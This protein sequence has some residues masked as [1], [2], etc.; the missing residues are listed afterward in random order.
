MQ[1]ER[2]QNMFLS[3]GFIKV[4]P[5]C[6]HKTSVLPSAWLRVPRRRW[7]GAE[8]PY[9]RGGQHLQRRTPLRRTG[10]GS[11]RGPWRNPGARC[12]TA[13]F[14]SRTATQEHFFSQISRKTFSHRLHVSAEAR[15]W[16]MQRITMATAAQ[17]KTEG[18][19]WPNNTSDHSR[20]W[21]PGRKWETRPRGFFVYLMQYNC[22][23]NR[24]Y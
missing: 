16:I 10:P 21:I 8:T 11:D 20:M 5:V 13:R 18:F 15:C 17:Q 7:W 12:K 14:T 4:F 6:W 22:I 24:P 23:I 2:E 3:P 1:P 9:G 19:R